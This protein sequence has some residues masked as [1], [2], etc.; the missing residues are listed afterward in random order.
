MPTSYNRKPTL[1]QKKAMEILLADHGNMPVSK[2]MRKAGY[3]ESMARNSQYLTR[4]PA[5]R[6]YLDMVGISDDFL[7]K[8]HFEL[9][10]ASQI[11][12]LSFGSKKI[13]RKDIEYTDT[14]IRTILE[15]VPGLSIVTIVQGQLKGERIAYYF[16]PDVNTQKGV[17]ELTYK[18]KG[19]FSPAQ[20]SVDIHQE[21]TAE[22]KAMFDSIMKNNEAK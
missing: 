6:D 12:H 5:F 8:K 4:S 2:A 15:K 20:L 13:G 1:R 7:A 9:L 18:L 17:L 10:R 11:G 3:S 22:E 21:L 16:V 19:Y 14:E